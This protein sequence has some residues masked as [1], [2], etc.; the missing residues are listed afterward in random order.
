[1][2]CSQRCRGQAKHE[3][4]TDQYRSDPTYRE[5]V[6]ARQV[7]RDRARGIAPRD[8]RGTS[9]C[10]ECGAPFANRRIDAT[11]VKRFCQARC[12]KRAAKRREKERAG[13]RWVEVGA[14]LATGE[15]RRVVAKVSCAGG[16]LVDCP[17]CTVYMGVRHGVDGEWDRWCPY[18]GLTLS[19]NRE[20]AECQLVETRPVAV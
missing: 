19:L 14:L 1:M 13:W 7:A 11:R 20:E 10:E 2:Y 18:C 16:L 12:A 8:E 3:R 6:R 15:G 5:R 17:C 4:R 9:E